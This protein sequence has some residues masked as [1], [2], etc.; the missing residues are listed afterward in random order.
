MARQASAAAR[1]DVF[2]WVVNPHSGSIWI[3]VK[4]KNTMGKK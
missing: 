1:E 3:E 2:E 4:G